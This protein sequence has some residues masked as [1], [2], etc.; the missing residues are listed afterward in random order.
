[1]LSDIRLLVVESCSRHMSSSLCQELGLFA[2]QQLVVVTHI[3]LLSWEA[4]PDR[5][6]RNIRRNNQINVVFY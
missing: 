4:L 6:R 2:G 1:M 3:H 5:E